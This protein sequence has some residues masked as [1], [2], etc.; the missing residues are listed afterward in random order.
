MNK[1]REISNFPEY[2]TK[3]W[4]QGNYIIAPIILRSNYKVYVNAFSLT[5]EISHTIS[6]EKGD[7]CDS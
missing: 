1:A 2:Q 5:T 3:I 7:V 6:S 4:D